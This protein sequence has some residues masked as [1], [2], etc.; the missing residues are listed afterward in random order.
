MTI[1]DIEASGFGA[2]GYPIEIGYVRDDGCSWCSLIRP[3]PEWT[4]WDAS[5]QQVHGI[6]R[7]QV[8]S[9]GRPAREIAQ[10]LNTDLAG[11][12][13]YSDAWAHD[14]AWLA[15]LFDAAG[16]APRFRLES[17]HRLIDA[18]QLPALADHRRSAFDTLQVRRHRASSDARA[19][20]WALLQVQQQ[21]G[22]DPESRPSAAT[23]ER[24]T[25][26]GPGN[27]TAGG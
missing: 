26:D 11:R 7:V 2:G 9:Q 10:R 18:D 15:Q 21:A 24:P 22:T 12:T 6:T 4:R 1:L 3:E 25:R 20:Q 17:I 23:A 5:A 8:E 13:A 19:L 27:P 16:L 14:Y